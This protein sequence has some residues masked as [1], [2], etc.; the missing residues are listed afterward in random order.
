VNAAKEAFEGAYEDEQLGQLVD[1][2]RIEQQALELIL[3][4][5]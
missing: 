4:D 5:S 1:R 3:A 2:L